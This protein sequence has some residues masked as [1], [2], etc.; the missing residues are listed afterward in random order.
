[1]IGSVLPFLPI[2]DV[3][4][5]MAEYAHVFLFRCESCHGALTS[6]C[7]KN[8]CNLEM[9]DEQV[10]RSTCD[11]GWT[12]ELIGFVAVRHWVQSWEAVVVKD[13]AERTKATE[14]A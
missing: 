3:M 6:V 8:E 13:T 11:C 9:A 7:F 12:G 1:V 2:K 14:A 5:R 10:F 4:A